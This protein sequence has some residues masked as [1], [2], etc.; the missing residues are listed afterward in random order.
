MK[1]NRIHF[2]ND[3]YKIVD[4]FKHVSTLFCG[5]ELDIRY[6]YNDLRKQ[7]DK[8]VLSDDSILCYRRVK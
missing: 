7:Y 1:T 2:T 3:G 4:G 6:W 8:V 5:K